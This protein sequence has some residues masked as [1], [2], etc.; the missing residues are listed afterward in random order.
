LG[1]RTQAARDKVFCFEF[2]RGGYEVPA[3]AAAA[4]LVDRSEGARKAIRLVVSGRRSG[5]ETDMRTVDRQCSQQAERFEHRRARRLAGDVG[6]ALANRCSILDKY[7]VKLCRFRH[8]REFDEVVDVDA[9]VSHR[10]RMTPCGDVMTSGHKE[11][12]KL[13][14]S[15]HDSPS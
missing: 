8:L 10:I 2:A 3:C 1:M 14:L 4:E 15:H 11:G 7:H 5:N 9:G 12:P 13:H 6:V